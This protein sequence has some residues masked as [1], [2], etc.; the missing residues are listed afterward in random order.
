MTV[1]IAALLGGYLLGAVPFAYIVTRIV[2]GVDIRTVDIG[3]SGAGSV[4]RYVG[5]R[6]G[7][8]VAIGDVGKGAAAVALAQVLGA[9]LSIAFL[10]G[11]AAVI[12]HIWPV[13]IGFRG[14]QG[15]ATLI[16]VFFSLAWLATGLTLLLMGA[17]LLVNR[18]KASRRLFLV[19]AIAAPVLPALVYLTRGSIELLLYTVA[20]ILFI[21]ARNWERLRHPRTITER[22]LGEFSDT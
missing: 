11:M 1:S 12:G 22:L 7:V 15:V 16:G 20:G 13:Y 6:A 5:V 2:K 18:S 14:G 19:V 17:G 8:L 9:G 10:S 21:V 3:N 4:I